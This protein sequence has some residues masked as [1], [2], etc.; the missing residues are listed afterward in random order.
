MFMATWQYTILLMLIACVGGGALFNIDGTGQVNQYGYQL[1]TLML[2]NPRTSRGI[3]VAHMLVGRLTARDLQ[4]FLTFVKTIAPAWTPRLGVLDKDMTEYKGIQ[5]FADDFDLDITLFVCFFHVLQAV[6]RWC[7][8]SAN[9]VPAGIVPA[10]MAA[11]SLMHYANTEADFMEL[12]NTLLAFLVGQNAT[13]LI[14]YLRANWF[15]GPFAWMWQRC[16]VPHIAELMTYTNNYLE[17]WHKLIKVTLLGGKR[18]K[19]LDR[20]VRLLLVDQEALLHKALYGVNFTKLRKKL[21]RGLVDAKEHSSLL[22]PWNQQDREQGTFRVKAGIKVHDVSLRGHGAGP[23]CTCVPAQAELC[24][25]ILI[26]CAS[27]ELAWT[28]A[29][30]VAFGFVG[31]RTSVFYNTFRG[32]TVP[33]EGDDAVELRRYLSEGEEEN[34]K[35]A[36]SGGETLRQATAG[37]LFSIRQLMQQIGTLYRG[38]K[39]PEKEYLRA[40]MWNDLRTMVE[41]SDVKRRTMTPAGAKKKMPRITYGRPKGPIVQDATVKHALLSQLMNDNSPALV[42]QQRGDRE[43]VK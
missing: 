10:V 17:S 31:A 43:K 24:R 15:T 34:T 18:N 33:K 36:G 5:D 29:E 23:T 35:K 11:M 20:L 39:G 2:I 37:T 38:R 42:E 32:P 19:R 28:I 16:Y 6:Q 22:M 40:I 27:P 1:V 3:P 9:G 14:F 30:L 12:R 4:D 25:E 13:K 21:A 8:T 41:A 7:K 26:V